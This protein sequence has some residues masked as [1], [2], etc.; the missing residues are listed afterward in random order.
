MEAGRERER[1]RE[2]E[3]EGRKK[4]RKRETER[5]KS[6]SGE[7]Q[8]RICEPISWHAQA[9]HE[10]CADQEI[11]GRRATR[12][13]IERREKPNREATSKKTDAKIPGWSHSRFQGFWPRFS[14]FR[15][16][17]MKNCGKSKKSVF[18]TPGTK[19]KL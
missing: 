12:A 6:K 15:I 9:M 4:Q 5:G 7:R 3:S 1:E 16:F 18:W 10:L 17:F 2:R 11:E 8:S 13:R 14:D 19:I